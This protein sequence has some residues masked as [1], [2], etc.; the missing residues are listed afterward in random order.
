MIAIN[1][2]VTMTIAFIVTFV[3]PQ[4]YIFVYIN[5]FL[6][7]YDLFL[8]LLLSYYLFLL[9]LSKINKKYYVIFIAIFIYIL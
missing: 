8:L 3:K 4:W 1:I 5:I 6:K 9:S 2:K 7:S